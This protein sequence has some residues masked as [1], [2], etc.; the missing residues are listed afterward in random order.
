[1]VTLFL[2]TYP[3]EAFVLPSCSYSSNYFD[4]CY[5]MKD[6]DNGD[7]YIGDFQNNEKHGNGHYRYSNGDQYIGEFFEGVRTG[8]GQYFYSNGDT[9][10]GEMLNGEFHGRG[11]YVYS[12]GRVETSVWEYNIYIISDNDKPKKNSTIS[13]MELCETLGFSKGTAEFRKCVL[14][15]MKN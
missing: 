14:E 7:Q 9:Y 15:V 11:K 8:H 2:T 12:D 10:E 6:Y 5:G 3:L 1:M 13:S 4:N